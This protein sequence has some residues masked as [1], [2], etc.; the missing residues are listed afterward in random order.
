[1]ERPVEFRVDLPEAPPDARYSSDEIEQLLGIPARRVKACFF[2]LTRG[3]P[4]GKVY[5]TRR[6]VEDLIARRKQQAPSAQYALEA[7]SFAVVVLGVCDHPSAVP[8]LVEMLGHDP[9]AEVRGYA[10]AGL[11][12][13]GRA[14]AVDALVAGLDDPAPGVRDS[15]ARTLGHIRDARAVAPLGAAMLDG[16]VAPED[17]VVALEMIGGPEAAEALASA[18]AD[19]SFAARPRAA[20][21]LWHFRTDN[22][23]QALLGA[24]RDEDP[25]L[26]RQAAWALGMARDAAAVEPL[27]ERL[28]EDADAGVRARA[29]H[30]LAQLGARRAIPLLLDAMDGP[31]PDVHS[32]ALRAL[33]SLTGED[34][35]DDVEFCRQWWAGNKERFLP[36]APAV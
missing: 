26:R 11:R 7:R 25:E 24:L 4:G 30:A 17:A 9:S 16:S 28:E 8:A 10:A 3:R 13:G 6:A 21:A 12:V 15:C 32:E 22:A 1:V 23:V 34:L 5:V 35:A 31:E 2:A 18:I 33:R 20:T 36:P 29:A 14:E 27:L 19:E